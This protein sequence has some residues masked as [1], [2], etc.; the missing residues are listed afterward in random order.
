[1][2]RQYDQQGTRVMA[3]GNS[4]EPPETLLQALEQ[5]HLALELLDSSSAPASIG[6][7]VDFAIHELYHLIA[8]LGAGTR[9]AQ[10]D[11]NAVPQ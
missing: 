8:T 3:D 5:L 7:K 4:P 10:I 11:R 2:G 9:L 1:M 6:A